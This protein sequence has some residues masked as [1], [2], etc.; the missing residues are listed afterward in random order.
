MIPADLTRQNARLKA[1]V[2]A[3]THERNELRRLLKRATDTVEE[4]AAVLEVCL[5]R[6]KAAERAE[7]VQ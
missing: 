2:A 1:R 3:L 7:R 5:Q 4:S 6:I